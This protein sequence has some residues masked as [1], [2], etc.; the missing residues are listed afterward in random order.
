MLDTRKHPGAEAAP[1]A[2]SFWKSPLG[3]ACTLAAVAVSVY[4]WWAHQDHVLALVPYIFL[5]AC[6]L[7]HMFMHRG[8]HGHR[9]GSERKDGRVVARDD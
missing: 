7:M 9:H 5:A 1:A 3:I 6:P 4:L 2:P 8:G